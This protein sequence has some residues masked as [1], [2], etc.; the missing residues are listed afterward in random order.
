MRPPCE[1]TVNKVL[2]NVRAELVKILINEYSMRQVD[3]AKLFGITQASVSQYLTANRGRD[4]LL[5]EIFPEIEK[6]ARE[7]AKNLVENKGQIEDGTDAWEPLCDICRKI[8][9]SSKFSTYC[10][11]AAQLKENGQPNEDH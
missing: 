2:P 3:V 5:L 11:E 1:I 7:T 4:E 6:Y 9:K 8:L 10:K